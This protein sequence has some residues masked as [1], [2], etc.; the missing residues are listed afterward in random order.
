MMLN[1]LME[2]YGAEWEDLLDYQW[3]LSLIRTISAIEREGKTKEGWNYL[4]TYTL[5]DSFHTL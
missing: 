2:E 4:R 3:N 5:I 1:W